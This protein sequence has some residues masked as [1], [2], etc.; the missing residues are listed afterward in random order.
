MDNRHSAR[1]NE[2]IKP[3]TD[4]ELIMV[5]VAV[6]AVFFMSLGRIAAIT[7]FFDGDEEE[8]M[9]TVVTKGDEEQEEEGAEEAEGEAAQNHKLDYDLTQY[10]SD[11]GAAGKLYSYLDTYPEAAYILR[12]LD[13]YPQQMLEF[14]ARF[15]E[16]MGFA[17][18]YLDFDRMNYQPE[19]DL[20]GEV[21]RGEMPYLLQWDSRWGYVEYGDG[22]I[23]YSGCGPTCLS[24]VAM[25]YYGWD[26]NDPIAVARYADENDYYVSGS[27]SSWTLMSK[28]CKDFDLIAKEIILDENAMVKALEAGKPIICAMGPGVFTDNGHYIVLTG[29]V[30]GAFTI[31]DPNSP[32]NTARTWTYNEIKDQIRN[33]WSFAPV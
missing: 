29:Y 2:R 30:D 32:A 1:T 12:N 17:A 8:Q 22:M 16:A 20:S 9:T 24:M 3:R 21:T 13:L 31:H 19:L 4:L 27:G 10:A 7:A 14:V 33:I 25:Y 23:G 28:G 18:S 6:V 26:N 11:E 15:P 5:T